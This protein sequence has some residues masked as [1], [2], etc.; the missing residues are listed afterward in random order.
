MY[1][2]YAKRDQALAAAVLTVRTLVSTKPPLAKAVLA[3]AAVEAL[4]TTT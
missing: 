4:P 2:L 3:I 1:T